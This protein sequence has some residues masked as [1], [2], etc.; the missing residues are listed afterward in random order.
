MHRMIATS[1]L[2]LT[3]LAPGCCTC[4]DQYE[5][6]LTQWQ[7]ELEAMRPTMQ[8]GADMLPDPKLT[9]TKMARYD[10]VVQGIKRVNGA[11]PEVFSETVT[12][13]PK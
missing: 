8:K 10:R 9:I 1:L 12:E 13:A 7:G 6:A 3:L 2:V 11:G 5:P 4:R